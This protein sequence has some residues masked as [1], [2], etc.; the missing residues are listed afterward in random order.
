LVLYLILK[1]STPSINSGFKILQD[2]K[3]TALSGF[4][5]AQKGQQN[6]PLNCRLFEKTIMFCFIV[7]NILKI[8]VIGTIQKIAK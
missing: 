4:Q 5:T 8:V 1:F 3:K 2:K 6:Q 7:F